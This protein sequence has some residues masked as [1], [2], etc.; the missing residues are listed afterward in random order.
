MTAGEMNAITSK[1]QELEGDISQSKET[2]KQYDANFGA[3]RQD[4]VTRRRFLGGFESPDWPKPPSCAWLPGL[5][6]APDVRVQERGDRLTKYVND[7]LKL[8]VRPILKVGSMMIMPLLQCL[9][10]TANNMTK[11]PP[12]AKRS[13]WKEVAQRTVTPDDYRAHTLVRSPN[14]QHVKA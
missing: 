5:R 14:K 2:Q 13:S 9:Q 7:V 6:Q 12:R 1:L 4:G 8:E 11:L 10:E 3:A